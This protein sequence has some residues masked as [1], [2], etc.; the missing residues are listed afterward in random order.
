MEHSFW[1]ERW[2]KDEI[3]FHLKD[4]NPFLIKHWQRLHADLNNTVFVPLCGKSNDLFWLAKRV[5][6]VIGIELS[7]QAVED[8]FREN[9]LTP[10]LTEREFFV[11]Y[12]Y[13]NITML[14][15][16]FFALTQHDLED[17]QFVYDRASLIAL[18]PA[19]RKDYA[20]K[21]NELLPNEKQ[22][23]LLTIDYP[24]HEIN[25]PPHAVPPEEI[26]QLFAEKFDITTLESK[27]ILAES[28]RFK[29]KGV[30]QMDEYIYLLNKK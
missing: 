12:R 18:P 20:I 23:L 11:E 6:R 15:G 22:R 3:G 26:K 17:C 2:D 13:K 16:D 27:N 19:M 25:G 14:C 30:T 9:K 1:H 10:K 24:Q 21:L 7:R 28:Q 29:D 8:F 5:K 4:T